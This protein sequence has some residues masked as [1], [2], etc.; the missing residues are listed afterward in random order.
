MTEDEKKDA[1]VRKA[2]KTKWGIRTPES[3]TGLPDFQS[4]AISHSANFPFAILQN[5]CQIMFA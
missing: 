2:I 5:L 1:L 3:A 4:G